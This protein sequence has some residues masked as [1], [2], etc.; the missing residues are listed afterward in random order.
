[1]NS[2]NRLI[3]KSILIY[4]FFISICK[5]DDWMELIKKEVE[6]LKTPFPSD[7]DR[8]VFWVNSSGDITTQYFPIDEME[9]AFEENEFSEELK[10]KI[11]SIIWTNSI[12]F[13]SF[14]YNQFI[15]LSILVETAGVA[16]KLDN[17]VDLFFFTSHTIASLRPQYTIVKKKMLNFPIFVR[18]LLLVRR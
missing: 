6:Q 14:S 18:H 12:T 15:G 4:L 7:G 13:Q 10:N 9:E 3:I 16:R 2:I 17:E 1:M 8:L 5:C 11:R